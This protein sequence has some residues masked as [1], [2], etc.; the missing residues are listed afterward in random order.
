MNRHL[1]KFLSKLLAAI[2]ITSLF[3]P[4]FA[5]G[6]ARPAHALG[7]FAGP[8]IQPLAASGD[9][10]HYYASGK[11]IDLTPSLAWVSVKFV[12]ANPGV[13]LN[14]LKSS[15]APLNAAG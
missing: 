3:V 10:F 12:D 9:S 11:R 8:G 6:D 7:L 15:G 5:A 13:Q 2:A 4:G 1:S 14:A